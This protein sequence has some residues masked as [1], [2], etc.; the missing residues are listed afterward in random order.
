MQIDF[1]GEYKMANTYFLTR[2]EQG[3]LFLFEQ[4]EWTSFV[5]K[6]STS[7]SIKDPRGRRV[8]FY[9]VANAMELELESLNEDEL[10]K[11]IKENKA[12]WAF[13]LSGDDGEN[14]RISVKSADEFYKD[15][16]RPL[17]IAKESKMN[18]IT[19]KSTL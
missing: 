6:L 13:L 5:D 18:I 4:E 9:F 7:F 2:G 15:S 1:L 3:Q 16:R 8:I 10:I 12:L 19:L 17:M 11:N 14:V